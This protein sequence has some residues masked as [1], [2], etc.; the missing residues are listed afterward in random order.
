MVTV[1]VVMRS[2]TLFF[3]LRR[4]ARYRIK[5]EKYEEKILSTCSARQCTTEQM[6]NKRGHGNHIEL[7]KIHEKLVEFMTKNKYIF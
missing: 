6:F 7:K 2:L 5:T 4:E 1:A 3:S